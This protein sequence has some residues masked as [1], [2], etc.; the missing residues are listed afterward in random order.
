MGT[1]WRPPSLPPT[2]PPSPAFGIPD[3]AMIYCLC[4]GEYV[5][6]VYSHVTT[7]TPNCPTVLSDSSTP[8]RVPFIVMTSTPTVSFTS[9]E[10]AYINK[11]TQTGVA[12]AAFHPEPPHLL[13]QQGPYVPHI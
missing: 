6:K 11:D 8:L 4:Q 3:F 13:F 9:S 5:L 12:P 10:M 7:C 1:Q 2:P